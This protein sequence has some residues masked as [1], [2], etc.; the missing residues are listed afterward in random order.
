MQY[1]NTCHDNRVVPDD[2]ID[3]IFVHINRRNFG[4]RKRGPE[5]TP[6]F[7]V[8][9]PRDEHA[10]H[11]LRLT[12]SVEIADRVKEPLQFA[13]LSLRPVLVCEE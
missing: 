8:P 7:A 10:C 6:F 9:A 11:R 13:Q 2:V 4:V 3:F 12:I 1:L 5:A